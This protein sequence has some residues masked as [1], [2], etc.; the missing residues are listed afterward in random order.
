MATAAAIVF[1][2]TSFARLLGPMSSGLASM[3]PLYTSILAVFNHMK[4][5]I[6]ARAVLKGVV[7][8]AFGAAVF[9][10]IVASAQG[11]LATGL[12]FGLATLAAVAVPALLFSCFKQTIP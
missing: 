8:G 11:S 10:V 12:C 9:F 1:L 4:S 2:L 7:A 3:F 5:D 6:L